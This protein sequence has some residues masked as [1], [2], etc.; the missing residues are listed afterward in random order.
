MTQNEIIRKLNLHVQQNIKITDPE[1]WNLVCKNYPQFIETEIEAHRAIIKTKMKD[2][3]KKQLKAYGVSWSSSQ[4]GMKYFISLFDTNP[5]VK[6]I[7]CKAKI[8]AFNIGKLAIHLRDIEGSLTLM[9]HALF[10]H[11]LI[12]LN[13]IEEIEN[14][15]MYNLEILSYL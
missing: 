11:E 3:N 10:E 14:P 6:F 15:K 1:F 13:Y 7:Y 5:K 9:D 4:S 12:C 2:L 8:K